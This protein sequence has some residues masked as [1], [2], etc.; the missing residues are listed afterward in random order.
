MRPD[1]VRYL[2]SEWHESIGHSLLIALGM[3]HSI[4]DAM[5]DHD[6]PRPVPR[7][8]KNLADVIYIANL[9]A[10][11]KFEWLGR[12]SGVG[13]PENIELPIELIDLNVDVEKREKEMRSIFS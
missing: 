8:P 13:A 11:G 7:P 4:A 3:P 1:T 10:G 6:R 5:R 2:I 12:D 9:M